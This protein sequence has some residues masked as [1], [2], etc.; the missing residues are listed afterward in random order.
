MKKALQLFFTCFLLAYSGVI[1][2][3]DYTVSSVDEYNELSLSAGDVVTWE[4]GNYSSDERIKFLGNGTSNNPIILKAETPG[5]VVFTGGLKMNIAGSYLIVDGFYWNGGFGASNFIQFR[6]GTNYA[7]NCTIQNCA[8]NGLRVDPDDEESGTSV[9]H[10]WIVMYGNYNTVTNCSFM[11]K[12]NAGALILT[13][14]EFNAEEDRCKEIGH[15]ISNNYFYN[16]EKIDTSLTNAGDSETIRIGTSEYQNVNSGCTISNN[17]FVQADGE[18]EIISNKSMNNTYTNNTFRRSRGSLVMRH[19]ANATVDGNYFL[20]E[21]VEGTGGIRIADSNHQITNNYIQDCISSVAQI[22]WNNGLTF[23]GGNTNSVQN[24][25]TTSVSN[26][27]QDVE[28]INF[29]NNT[30]I[31]THSPFYFNATRDGA[32]DVFGDVTNNLIYFASNNNNNTDV[33]NGS[34]SEIGTNLDFS[35]NVYNSATAIGGSASG[36]S[37]ESITITANGEIFSHN[38]S[39]KGA[40]I[41]NAPITDNMVGNGIGACFLGAEG[42]SQSDCDGNEIEVPSPTNSLTVSS[43]S[44]FDADGGSQ[45]VSISSNVN[46]TVSENS[47]WISVNNTS[48]SNNGSVSITVSQNTSTND[49]SANVTISGSGI[50]RLVSVSQDGAEETEGPTPPS[51]TGNLALDG[52]ASQSSTSHNGAAS[53]AIDGNTN[54]VWRNASVTHTTA[55]TGSWWQVEL[56]SQVSIGDIVIYNRTCLLYTSPSPRDKRQSRMPSSA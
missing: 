33:L 19:G 15:T 5:G 1:N 36:F 9:K 11:N 24:C 31:N 42:N 55:T 26:N 34:Y 47:S 51:N 30:F 46:W 37:Q 3:T 17:Y 28:N 8:I 16:Y 49:R 12:N 38:Q 54:G 41:S 23:V 48:G 7:Q 27:Y 22:P 52:T 10:R 20:G 25:N 56:D 18:N 2:A 43:I 29:S 50:T 13:E 35:G 40:S 14:N 32:D 44:D 45:T 6:D 21:N 4:N 53:R 39:G